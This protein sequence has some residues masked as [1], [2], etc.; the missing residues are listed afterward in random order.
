M[1]S[2]IM[3]K[4]N[5]VNEKNVSQSKNSNT[6]RI[7]AIDRFRGIAIFC[8]IVFQFIRKFD[9]FG[10]LTRIASHNINTGIVV[11]ANTTIA[12]LIAPMFMFAIALTYKMS[13]DRR[14][15][16]HGKKATKMHFLLR[17][18]GLIGVGAILYTINVL[19]DVMFSG[20]A[21]R[22]VDYIFV[23]FSA[24][25]VLA[26]L[27]NLITLIKP[28]KKY[29]PI[30]GK[31]FLYIIAVMGVAT[32]VVG[33]IDFVVL[34]ANI[35]TVSKIGYW[36]VLQS[37]GF[38]GLVALPFMSSNFKIRAIAGGVLLVIY[39]LYYNLGGGAIVGAITQGG[40]IGGFGW[41]IIILLGSAFAEVYMKNKKIAYISA[42]AGLAIAIAM[43]FLLPI[44]KS[45]VE[46]DPTYLVATIVLSA[47]AFLIVD[48][49]HFYKFSFDP[50]AW[51]GRYPILLYL[52]E[53]GVI[54]LFNELAP[55]SIQKNAP[56]WLAITIVTVV[57]AGFTTLV[58][59]LNRKNKKINL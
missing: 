7:V 40:F 37:L 58:Y 17:Y 56:L 34:T 27:F 38:A 3:V 35:T 49:F 46:P 33:A 20:S 24:L 23:A 45:G 43:Y 16:L 28:I 21:L 18:L 36:M 29:K 9:A 41:A 4:E 57:V 15:Q 48:L 25:A 22:V 59:F 44:V 26:I 6:S 12:D 1:E 32:I 47:I 53:F 55:D 51:W 52:L 11:F 19:M 10:F 14:A 5:L 8:M 54:G 30:A 50:L 39:T 42:L 31:V 2:K 13:Y